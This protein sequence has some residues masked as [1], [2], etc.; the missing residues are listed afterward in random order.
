MRN[1]LFP[2]PVSSPWMDA[3]Y[4]T[5][6]ATVFDLYPQADFCNDADFRSFESWR[7]SKT[8][9]SNKYIQKLM[10]L[11]AVV[12]CRRRTMADR[13]YLTA[14]SARALLAGR[15]YAS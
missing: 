2:R 8:W 11:A 5:P 10:R 6:A 7:F 15:I 3:V 12:S 14:D 13:F 1:L 9:I 4:S